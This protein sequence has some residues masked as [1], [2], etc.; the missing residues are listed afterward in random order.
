MNANIEPFR[1]V[2]ERTLIIVFGV[3][4]YLF[5]KPVELKSCDAVILCCCW[6]QSSIFSI[7][8]KNPG[9]HSGILNFLLRFYT[10][11]RVCEGK[12]MYKVILKLFLVTNLKVQNAEFFRL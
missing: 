11:I 12:Y 6:G 4:Q 10:L 9:V 3:Q 8:T 5:G 2:E 7:K 1:F